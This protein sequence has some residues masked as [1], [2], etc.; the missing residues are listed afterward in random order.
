MPNTPP[1]ATE[2]EKEIR[3]L[4][5]ERNERTFSQDNKV[6]R[7]K[8]WVDFIV[9]LILISV[10]SVS[11]SIAAFYWLMPQVS[12][13]TTEQKAKVVV[14]KAEL[15][16]EFIKQ[17]VGSSVTVF[18]ARVSK[19]GT[20]L[21]DQSYLTSEA[22][23]QAFVL[24]SDGW[25]VTTQAVVSNTK[26]NYLAMAGDGRLY[27]VKTV[28][29]DPAAPLAYLKID[30]RNLTALPFA[31]PEDILLNEPV[32][33]IINETQNKNRSWYL[34]YLANVVARTP[35]STRTD[36]ATSSEVLPDRYI[37]DQD[38][39]ENSQGAPIVDMQGRVIGLVADYDGSLR[40]V[41]P[42]VNLLPVMDK[43][44]SQNRAWRPVLGVT[45]VQ[46]DWLITS[47]VMASGAI[48]TSSAKRAAVVSKSPAAVAG[49]KEGDKILSV[50][51][52]KLGS[53]SL[54]LMLQQYRPGD[55]IDLVVERA[56]KE[57][58][59]KVTLGEIAGEFFS[60]EAE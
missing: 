57:Q 26:G 19:G 27:E 38:L 28:A 46:S 8:H 49:L 1:P 2:Y 42:L 6:Q 58:T 51:G 15:S 54:S 21:V 17:V 52:V 4:Y 44:F 22:L 18:A 35:L 40:G 41:F 47:E 3:A 53:A 59:V 13:P 36:L 33:T 56:G 5:R 43:L 23:G 7:G 24:S 39:P 45:Y 50:A 14:T 12:W 37:L 48:L 60:S 11:A 29:L 16:S 10:F 9:L 20:S 25:L 34:R 31:N 55:I 30:T 32:V